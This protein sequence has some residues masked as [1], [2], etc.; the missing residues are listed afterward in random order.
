VLRAG[1]SGTMPGGGC[2]MPLADGDP[3]AVSAEKLG[4][5]ES[6]DTRSNHNDPW[7]C[8]SLRAEPRS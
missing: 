6:I 4:S 1:G 5:R 3:M 2:R 8:A 7:P